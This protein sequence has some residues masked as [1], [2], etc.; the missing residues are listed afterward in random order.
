MKVV[1][2]QKKQYIYKPGSVPHVVASIINLEWR[3]ATYFCCF[4]PSNSREQRS[5]VGLLGIAAHRMPVSL[6]LL[7]DCSSLLQGPNITA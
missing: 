4:L 1:N 3:I 7:R 5:N 6:P 2:F